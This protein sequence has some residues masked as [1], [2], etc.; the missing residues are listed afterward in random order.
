MGYVSPAGR[1]NSHRVVAK[2]YE[3]INVLPVCEA[4][5]IL[6]GLEF[7]L[8]RQDWVATLR[9]LFLAF[10][11]RQVV[12]DHNL[13]FSRR[14]PWL[15]RNSRSVHFM[16]FRIEQGKLEQALDEKEL[17][18]VCQQTGS[19]HFGLFF[20]SLGLLK[21]ASRFIIGYLL[22]LKAPQKRIEI[23]L[24][25]IFAE[26]ESCAPNVSDS[27]ATLLVNLEEHLAI[28]MKD[29]GVLTFNQRQL[30]LVP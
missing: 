1:R 28:D 11:M 19:I 12:A 22:D 14:D 3:S 8:A 15:V 30:D 17:I 25:T 21:R 5:L 13:T 24:G 7:R 18:C 29:E 23:V 20:L 2:V 4:I 6:L 16:I 9:E 26:S 10:P 27:D